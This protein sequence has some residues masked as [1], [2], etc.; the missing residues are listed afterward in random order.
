MTTQALIN[1]QLVTWARMRAGLSIEL[2]AKKLGIGAVDKIDAWEQGTAKPTFVQA[3]NIA[4]HTQIPFG[5][6][7]LN[8]PP[9][10]SLPIPDLRTFVNRGVDVP[11]NELRDIINQV[12]Q[13]QA[14]YKDYMREIGLPPCAVVGRFTLNDDIKTV[15]ADIRQCL[16]LPMPDKGNGESYFDNL[17]AAAENAGI[18]VMRSGIVGSNTRRKLQVSEFRGFAIYDQLAPVVFINSA[19]VKAARLFTLAHELAHLWLS[20]SGVSNLFNCQQREEARCNAI[21]GELL[22]PE[23]SFKTKWQSNIYWQDNLIPISKQ[24]HVSALVVAKRALDCSFIS[25]EVYGNYYQT[26]LKAFQQ[27]Q[28]SGGSF[29]NNTTAKNGKRL[30]RAATSQALSGHMLLRDAAQVLGIQPSQIERFSGDL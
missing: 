14:W 22:L 13:K 3:Q 16:N 6:L 21:A 2:L 19:D 30:M 12:L 7:F 29:I 17:V 10:E 8:Q 20:S 5:Y 4:K 9:A 25:Q 18:L 26:Q 28:S 23:I 24:F 27:K 1:P 11:S 15:V